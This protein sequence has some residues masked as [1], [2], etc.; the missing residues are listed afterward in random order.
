[1]KNKTPISKQRLSEVRRAASLKAVAVRQAKARHDPLTSISIRKSSK[2][3]LMAIADR[4]R[5]TMTEAFDVL[6]TRAL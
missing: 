5:T 2:A 6:V 3:K 1:M 4:E